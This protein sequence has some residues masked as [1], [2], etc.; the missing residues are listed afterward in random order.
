MR[1]RHEE[2]ITIV[3]PVYN[4]GAY[5]L[6]RCVN[7]ILYQSYRKLEIILVD[8]GSTDE[9]SAICDDW[10][11]RDDRV[12]VVH[13]KNGGL[14]AA[15]NTG[16]KKAKGKYI[17]YIDSDDWIEVDMIKCLYETL[18]E[19]DSDMSICGIILTDGEKKEFLPWYEEKC[20]FCMNDAYEELIKNKKITSHAWNKLYKI[21]IVNKVPFPE[22]K[23]YEDIRIMHEVFRLC[24]QV[25]VV[26]EYF[27]NYYRRT[28]SIVSTPKLYNKLEYSAAFR[29]RYEYVK[30]YTPQYKE[31]V[32]SQVASSI[33]FSI[34]QNQFSKEERK[35]YKDELLRAKKFLR[36][37]RVNKI[38]RK[39]CTCN[40][41]MYYYLAAVFW[42]FGNVIYRLLLKKFT[43]GYREWK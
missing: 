12:K 19:T 6:N 20:V 37:R 24:K 35:K 32:L 18:I 30:K 16:T 4:V 33:A 21:D 17:A 11:T 43:R 38:I 5:L 7:S 3:V 9:S 27:Y 22:G 36:T 31:I 8:D 29:D 28:N 25:V 1:C 2:L 42:G 41:R 10:A 23:I 13:R 34:V 15:R 40:V 14:S 39:N 26:K